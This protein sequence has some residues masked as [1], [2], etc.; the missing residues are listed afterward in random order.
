[1]IV[2]D[3]LLDL[4]FFYRMRRFFFDFYAPVGKS[5]PPCGIFLELISDDVDALK[6]APPIKRIVPVF[7]VTFAI[8]I[9]V[10]NSIQNALNTILMQIRPNGM[11]VLNI[12]EKCCFE[13]LFGKFFIIVA[14]L[15]SGGAEVFGLLPDG[16]DESGKS[17]TGK[18]AF[19]APNVSPKAP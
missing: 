3:K 11:H 2:D 7:V 9:K 1:M 4:V 13:C 15:L 6:Y 12:L 10:L 8:T 16:D 5:A 19:K 18:S 14:H 17:Q